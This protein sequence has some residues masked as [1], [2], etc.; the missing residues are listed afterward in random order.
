MPTEAATIRA[1]SPFSM[2]APARVWM[3]LAATEPKSTMPAPP[4]TGSGTTPMT[5]A[6]TGHRP[7]RIRM[8]PPAA[9]TNR[10]RTLVIATSPMFWA[11]ALHMNPLNS[12]LSALPRASARR[13]PSM[14]FSSAGRPTILPRARMSAVDSVMQ[15]SMT[16]HIEMIAA[17][18]N[19]GAPKWN[20]VGKPIRSAPRTASKFVMCSGS[21]M[22][23]PATSPSRMEICWRKPRRNLRMTSTI[24]RVRAAMPM[25]FIEP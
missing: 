5:E 15:T 20:G 12:G 14:V 18:W 6:A 7:S 24:A 9:T 16:M 13:P 3:P 10:L 1:F 8:P 11:K 25:F 2:A 23:V 21:A 19:C 17:T 22:R 4:R